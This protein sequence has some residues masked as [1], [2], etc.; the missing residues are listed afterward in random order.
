MKVLQ[1]VLS[2]CPTYS[3]AMASEDDFLQDPPSHKFI[4]AACAPALVSTIAGVKLEGFTGGSDGRGQL[5]ELL[6]LRD[7][8][9]PPIVHAYK[10][11]SQPGSIRAWLLHRSQTDRLC[12]TEGDFRIVL[13]DVRRESPSWGQ[14]MVVD[15]GAGNPM[16]IHI[17]PR[18]AHGVQ[19]RGARASFI[20]LP[21][22]IYDPASPDKFRI[23]PGDPRI[24]YTFHVA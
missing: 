3:A 13:Y 14:L 1:I 17:P 15:A 10:V 5:S 24:P 2:A 19:N 12:F 18:V 22:R 6:S 21:T 20:N 7:P 9:E 4:T 23:P 8:D 16:R 11:D